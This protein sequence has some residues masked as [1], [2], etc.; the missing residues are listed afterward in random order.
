MLGDQTRPD[1]GIGHAFVHDGRVAAVQ[2]VREAS[3]EHVGP[4]ELAGVEDAVA[5]GLEVEPVLR[6]GLATEERAVGVQHA[7]RVAA[8][9]GGIDE[10]GGILGSSGM[11]GLDAG[12]SCERGL[13]VVDGDA[14]AGRRVPRSHDEHGRHVRETLECVAQRVPARDVGDDCARAGVAREV[15][16]LL[17]GEQDRRRDRDGAA[18]HGAQEDDRIL[19]AVGKPDEHALAGTDAD[20]AEELREPTRPVCQLGERRLPDATRLVDDYR[21]AL[22]NRRPE[23]RVRAGDADVE[24]LGQRN[25]GITFSAKSR[26]GSRVSR[27]KNSITRSVQ[28]SARCRSI[29]SITCC[30]VPQMPCSSRPAPMWPP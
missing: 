17:G 20:V 6:R 26:A 21:R 3:A 12:D 8:R 1:G 28:P 23:V 16:D 5:V 13:E 9:P 25:A 30:G 15:H 27:P 11:G 18:F 22:R 4:V 7:L 19:E 14:T 2:R 10:V 24:M 29:R